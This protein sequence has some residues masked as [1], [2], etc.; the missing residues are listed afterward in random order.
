MDIKQLIE[1]INPDIYENLKRA[2]ELGKWADGVVLTAQ[3]KELCLQAI[4][5]YDFNHTPEQ[6]RVGYVQSLKSTA[7]E[8]TDRRTSS[9][10]STG[11]DDQ[12]VR[13]RDR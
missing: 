2:V 1:I 3:Q 4:I 13:W 12:P 8:Q 5:A 7:C 10:D 6:E 9:V 11:L